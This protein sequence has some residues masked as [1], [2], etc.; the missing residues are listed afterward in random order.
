MKFRR[1]VSA[2]VISEEETCREA[3]AYEICKPLRP[4][5]W[6]GVSS[7]IRMEPV[8]LYLLT[9]FGLLRLGADFFSYFISLWEACE[10][11]VRRSRG[12]GRSKM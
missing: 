4:S 5:L 12:A 6:E 1:C 8:D 9:N 2:T 10:R 7:I 11:R 3:V